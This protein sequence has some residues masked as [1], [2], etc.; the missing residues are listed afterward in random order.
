MIR[1]Q[2]VDRSDIAHMRVT[3][4]DVFYDLPL[5]AFNVFMFIFKTVFKR[6]GMPLISNYFWFQLVYFQMEP[7]VE[8]LGM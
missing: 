6:A 8:R 7:V 3:I 1:I 2:R 5:Y 4:R